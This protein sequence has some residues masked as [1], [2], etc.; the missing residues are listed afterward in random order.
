MYGGMQ[1]KGTKWLRQLEKEVALLK[2]FLAEAELHKGILE[3]QASA[4]KLAL[5]EGNF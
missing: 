2:K 5:A 1:K 3:R 4:N